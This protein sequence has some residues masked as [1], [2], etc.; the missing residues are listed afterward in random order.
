[1]NSPKRI[2]NK[3]ICTDDFGNEVYK[4]HYSEKPV[5]VVESIFIGPLI[6]QVNGTYVCAPDAKHA[7]VESKKAFDE[8]DANCNTCRNLDRLPHEKRELMRGMCA[9]RGEIVR[10]HPE[11]CMSMTCWDAR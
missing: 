8:M 3:A 11:D 2:L 10:F 5:S 7:Y 1:M 9:I 6:P 4:C